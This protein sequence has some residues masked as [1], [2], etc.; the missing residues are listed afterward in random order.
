METEV[1]QSVYVRC[2]QCKADIPKIAGGIVRCQ[3]CGVKLVFRK[4]IAKRL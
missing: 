2:P 4:G 1:Y 3:S